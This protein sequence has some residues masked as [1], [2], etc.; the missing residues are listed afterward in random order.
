MSGQAS[1]FFSTHTAEILEAWKAEVGPDADTPT[2]TSRAFINAILVALTADDLRPLTAY[3]E[4]DPSKVAGMDHR[5]NQAILHILALYRT[6][7]KVA[8]AD[9]M[10]PAARLELAISTVDELGHVKRRLVNETMMTLVEQF[11]ANSNASMARGTSLSITMHELRRPLTILNSYSQ[12]LSSGMLGTLPESATVA[13]EGISSSTEMM[14]RLV[15]A[16]SELSR[17][18]DPDDRL[19][20]EL[21]TLDEVVTGAVEP[22]LTEAEFRDTVIEKEI[23]KD[24]SIRGDR[25]RLLL[26]LTN[27][28]SNALKHSPPSGVVHVRAWQNDEHAH[29]MVRDQGPGF[30]PEDAAHLFDKYFRSTAERHRKI[31][32]SGLGLYIVR[33]IAR[34]HGGDVTARSKPGEGAEFEII[35]PLGG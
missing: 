16:L 24:V 29:F 15:N 26:A 25:R 7:D 28:L 9:G 4:L 23:E 20:M 12:L 1:D 33:T 10:E 32:G 22:L 2:R 18:E 8:E 21:L 3:Y 19:I 13:I 34:R 5:L 35:L 6:V 14:V 31:P 27:V 30:P 17:L 11:S